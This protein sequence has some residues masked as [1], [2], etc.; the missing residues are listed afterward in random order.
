MWNKLYLVTVEL[1]LD[2]AAASLYYFVCKMCLLCFSL[3][4]NKD[5]IK[6]FHAMKQH[7][8]DIGIFKPSMCY[9]SLYL[10]HVILLEAAAVLVMRIFGVSW[11]FYLLS[12]FLLAASQVFSSSVK[13]ANSY[14]LQLLVS[15]SSS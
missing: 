15:C 1:E 9:Y 5:L 8:E 2:V 11:P 7:L 10:I 4:Q 14:R 6:D 13:F 3:N 12:G